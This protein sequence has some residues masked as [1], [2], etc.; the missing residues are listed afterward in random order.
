M[1]KEMNKISTIYIATTFLLLL[2]MGI[3]LLSLLTPS[4]GSS[5]SGV[6][7]NCS[8]N[9]LYVSAED[10]KRIDEMISTIANT[11]S[12]GLLFKKGHL[13][14]LGAKVNEKVGPFAFLT[15]IFSHPEL[16]RDMKKIQSNSMKYTPFVKGLR[17]NMMRDYEAGCFYVYADQCIGALKLNKEEVT[18]ILKECIETA[19]ATRNK[20]AFKPFVDY[21]IKTKSS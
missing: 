16:A 21:L 20:P 9:A 8:S 10:G 11:S 6:K 18:A 14:D 15:Y 2:L 7:G 17:T 5:F 1:E 3:A 12:M 19:S 4:E 13:E